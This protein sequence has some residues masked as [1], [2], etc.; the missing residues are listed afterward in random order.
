MFKL[1]TYIEFVSCACGLN[2]D[3]YN[4]GK[5]FIYYFRCRFLRERRD[6]DPQRIENLYRPDPGACIGRFEPGCGWET[7][8]LCGHHERFVHRSVCNR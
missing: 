1:I 7:C 6:S 2:D 3:W 8:Q 5:L 4:V